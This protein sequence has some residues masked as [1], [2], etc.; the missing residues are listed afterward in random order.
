VSCCFDTE[1]L[2]LDED[3]KR[4]TALGYDE[5]FFVETLEGFKTLKNSNAGRCVFH[6]GTKCTIYENRPKG[7]KLYPIIFDV[8]YNKAVKDTFCPYREEFSLLPE[9]NRELSILY[10]RLLTERSQRIEGMKKGK[11]RA[12]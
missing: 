9:A 10:P 2:L 5:H 3:V 8:D 7:C 12:V 11:S 4:I 1:M 6:D